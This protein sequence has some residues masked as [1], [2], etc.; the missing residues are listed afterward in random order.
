MTIELL[1]VPMVKVPL[2]KTVVGE[3]PP[4]LPILWDMHRLYCCPKCGTPWARVE[5][6]G[7]INWLFISRGCCAAHRYFSDE[8][9]GSLIYDQG[10]LFA[11]SRF[12][13]EREVKLHLEQTNYG[14]D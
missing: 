4:S 10:D 12:A 8:W 9:S 6:D 11:F 3:S 14:K 2:G 1:F 7:A 5:F 13:L